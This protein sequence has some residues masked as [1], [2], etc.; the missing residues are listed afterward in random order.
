MMPGQDAKPKRA[1][2]DW[3]VRKEWE[4]VQHLAEV[5]MKM[6]EEASTRSLA[7][8]LIGPLEQAAQQLKTLAAESKGAQV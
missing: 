8:E 5:A 4:Q 6:L 7:E 2:V 3:Q 1:P